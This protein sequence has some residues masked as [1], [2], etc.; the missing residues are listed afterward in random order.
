MP[1]FNAAQTIAMAIESVRRQSC[2]DWEL[3]V[4]DDGSTDRTAAIVRGFAERDGRIR[5]V[6]QANQGCGPAR[7]VAV[8]AAVGALICRL[9]ADDLYL[10]EYLATMGRFIDARPSFDIYAC[11][12]WRLF[13][14]GRRK[15][16]H[17]GPRFRHEFSA[18]LD[19]L[20]RENLILP[21]AI[22]RKRVFDAAGGMRPGVYCE[23]YDFWLRAMCAGAKHVYCPQSLCLYRSSETQ[24]TADVVR[25]HECLVRVLGDV[26]ASGRLSPGQVKV[27]RHSVRLLDL[28]V[29]IRTRALRLLG[30]RCADVLFRYAHALAWTMRPYRLRRS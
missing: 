13:A 24:M 3:V 12:G 25:M 18:T 21:T 2:E 20:L 27:A 8:E 7:G 5:L 30:P 19:D 17:D 4:V 14:D 28:N 29:R 9:D 26:I 15:L 23:D 22:F 10:P 11:N 1:A 16:Y 6:H